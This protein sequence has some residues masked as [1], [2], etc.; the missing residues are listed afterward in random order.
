M[1]KLHSALHAIARRDIPETTDLWP[2]ITARIERKDIASMNP[3][4][5]LA[6]TIALVLFVLLALT[7]VAY[8]V[9]SMLGYIPG[10]GLVQQGTPIR[11][12]AAPVSVTRDGV[13][14]SVSQAILTHDK[15]TLAYHAFGIPHGAYPT[16]ESVMGCTSSPYLRLP[17]GTQLEA[18]S[19]FPP[20]PAD[21]DTATLV[22]PCIFDTLPGTVPADWELPLRFVP[23]PPDLTV[24]PVTEIL[25]SPTPAPLPDA[26]T[27]TPQAN[28]LVLTKAL[29][30]G[31]S[32]VLM[33]EF[34]F[35]ARDTTLPPGS[36]W[37]G[38]QMIKI[39]DAAGQDVPYTMPNDIDAPTPSGPDIWMTWIAQVKKGF[40]PPLTFTYKGE[41]IS[42]VGQA[43][44]AQ[45][46]FDAG[47]APKSGQQ[48]TLNRDFKLGGYNLRLVTVRFDERGGYSFDFK[49]DPGASA[50]Q[51]SVDIVGYTPICGGGGGGG[52]DFPVEFSVNV[53][54]ADPA[55]APKGVIK[56]T[57]GFQA[58]SRNKRS[59]QVQWQP[60]PGQAGSSATAT[61]QP[62]VCI[63]RGKLSQL[64]TAPQSLKGWAVLQ[65]EQTGAMLLTSLDGA[66]KRPLEQNASWPAF[67]PD[68]AHLSYAGPTAMRLLDLV[69][70]QV[71]DL[72]GI[73]ASGYN[74]HW[75]P[76]GTQLAF[77]D[78]TNG[79]IFVSAAD[80]TNLR[81]LTNN[82]DYKTLVGWSTDETQLYITAP[83]AG[84]WVLQSIDLASG[85]P[86]DLFTLQNASI[87]APNVTISP[88]GQWLAYRDRNLNSLYIVRIDGT[89]EHLLVDQASS[90][91]SAGFW[92]ADGTWLAVSLLDFDAKPSAAILVQPATCQAYLLSALHGSIQGL[93]LP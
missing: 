21:V 66:Q 59:Y 37:S 91:I 17:D 57:L 64:T 1:N 9:G 51:I 44:Q 35:D 19:D 34:H 53:C 76:T 6:W 39:S 36:W 70:G 48:W 71:S 8:A 27:S 88:D 26:A 3:K 75:S 30:I 31:D 61:P 15:T 16:S 5:K 2:H 41:V 46:E 14:V 72:P 67:L 82:A 45:F 83:G 47:A 90:G 73:T 43:Q 62:G 79:D 49:A 28:P 4:L 93:W 54:V 12:L 65:D 68:G 78:D 84:G 20:L 25:P 22:L 56:A 52:D 55:T 42:P 7:G 24:V 74:M 23:A 10:V 40:T 77:V 50:N 80:G 38:L 11:V 89:D 85:T 13:T 60:D 69:G 18:G 86:H 63:T 29:E 33:G 32:Y 87:K 81:R 58:L 92:S